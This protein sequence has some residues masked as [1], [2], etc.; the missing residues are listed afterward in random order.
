MRVK[1]IKPIVKSA[2]IDT[3][4]LIGLK[5]DKAPGE[6]IRM[7]HE[8]DFFAGE[9]LIAEMLAF[10]KRESIPEGLIWDAVKG[11]SWIIPEGS[12]ADQ[13][14]RIVRYGYTRGADL[15]HLACA[16]YLSPNSKDLAFL[17]L[18]EHQRGLASRLGF[19]TPI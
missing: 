10:G 14:A 12:L 3:S 19:S 5:F 18:D 16:I 4:L 7:V 9:L 11:I 8:Y 17:T 13:L 6:L 2:Y 15:W 1:A